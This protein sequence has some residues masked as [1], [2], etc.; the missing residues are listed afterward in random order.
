MAIR[1]ARLIIWAN[2]K[3][4]QRKKTQVGDGGGY[5]LKLGGGKGKNDC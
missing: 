1:F 3:R 2:E 5:Y 4:S